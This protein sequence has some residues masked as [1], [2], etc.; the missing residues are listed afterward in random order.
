MTAHRRTGL[1]WR[2]ANVRIRYENTIDD[3]VAFNRCVHSPTVRRA[4]VGLMWSVAAV[5][6]ALATASA[7]ASEEFLI[8]A[9][10][11]AYAIVSAW[12]VKYLFQHNLDRQARAMYVEGANREVL[13]PHELELRGGELIERTPFSESRTRLEVIERIASD[14]NYTFIYISAL[15]ALLQLLASIRDKPD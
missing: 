7:F 1:P 5:V 11:A 15:M 10:G 14:G 13:G 9:A 4:R 6:F 2:D 8:L 3:L 12:G